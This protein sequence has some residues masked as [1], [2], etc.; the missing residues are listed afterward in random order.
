MQHQQPHSTSQ[1]LAPVRELTA[2]ELELVAGGVSREIAYVAISTWAGGVTGFAI[3]S[4][5]PGWGNLAGAIGGG[6]IGL[7][8]GV[9]FILSSPAG[10]QPS[11]TDGH[12]STS[13]S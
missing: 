3:G 5:V 11:R 4:V 10:T 12:R 7:G 13:G 9:G 1:A 8:T 2:E 6:L